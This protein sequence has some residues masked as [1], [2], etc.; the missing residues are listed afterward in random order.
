M[1][2]YKP[3]LASYPDEI[4]PTYYYPKH[5]VAKFL[6]DA[7]DGHPSRPALEF[8]GKRLTYRRLREAAYRFANGLRRLGIGKGD[9]VAVMLPNCPPAVIAYFGT[10][11]AGAI[12]VQTNPLY[13]ENELKHQLADSGA[14]AIVT[15][16]LLFKRVQ[17]V[18]P[19]TDLRHVIIASIADYLPFPKNLLYPVKMKREGQQVN[20]PYSDDVLSFK[21]FLSRSPASPVDE[22]V[23][24]E[25]D[26][27]LLQYTGG[28]TGIAKGVMLTHRNLVANTYQISNWCY[29][30][31]EGKERF[32]A[33]LPLFHVFGL[34]VLM[35]QAALRAGMLILLPRFETET[36]LKTIHRLKPTIF[37][38]APTM[39]I[40]LLNHPRIREYDLSSVNVCV[41]GSAPLP[42]EVQ[43]RFE[44]LSGARLIEGYGLTEAS[45]VTHANPIWGRRKIGTIGIPFPDTEAKIVDPDTGEEKAAGEIGELIVRGPQVMAGYW[46]RPD[47]T[48]KV[49]KDGWLYTGDMGKMDADGYCSIVDR[50]K[51]M[52]IASGFKIYPR[53]IEEVL[54]E[55]PAVKEGVVAGVPDKY[56]GETVKAYVVLKDGAEL[57]GP[58][59]ETWCRQRLASYKV[60]RLYEFRDSLPKT[61][62]GKVLRRALIEEERARIAEEDAAA[63]AEE[64]R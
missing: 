55:H 34:T 53:E 41:S 63:A 37:P 52:I 17:T 42:L 3:W 38:G 25:K 35:N 1:E 18:L 15:L 10:L 31:E 11:L 23:D 2:T 9:R 29:K 8:L 54:Y 30:A 19:R 7:A 24:P 40:A 12:V 21:T 14:K 13:K 20:I 64:E 39:Y 51:E 45:P 32:L 27:A 60:P 59:L 44:E 6:L 46:N 48:E 26:I 57:T 4:A 49:L 61:M 33:A 58:E 47:E 50:K 56:R 36:V 28:T 62:I 16:D 22:K 43:E 5:N